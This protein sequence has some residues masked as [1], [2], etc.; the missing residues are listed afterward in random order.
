M[1][2]S[3]RGLSQEVLDWTPGLEINS[4]CMLVVHLSGAGRC[5]IGDAAACE[6]SG[7]DRAEFRTEGLETAL[8]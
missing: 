5:R 6:F 2:R 7:R 3:I 8:K 4:V 1:E